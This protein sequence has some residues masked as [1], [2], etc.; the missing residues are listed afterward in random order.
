[1]SIGRYIVDFICLDCRLILELDG[2]QHT[3]Q[4][5]YDAERTRWLEG[6]GFRVLRFWNYEVLQDWGNVEELIWTRLH[7]GRSSSV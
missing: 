3:F 1:M 4:R 6:Q 2:G 7:D 5:E